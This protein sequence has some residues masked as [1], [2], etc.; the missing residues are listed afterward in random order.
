[1]E[2]KQVRVEVRQN[3]TMWVEECASFQ[4]FLKAIAENPNNDEKNKVTAWFDG[5]FIGEFDY[6][7]EDGEAYTASELNEDQCDE[8]LTDIRKKLE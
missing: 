7:L 3:G 5:D 2:K 6:W 4:E 8:V 1:M